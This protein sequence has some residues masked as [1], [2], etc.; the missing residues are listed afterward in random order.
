MKKLTKTIAAI[1]ASAVTAFA[2]VQ[3]PPGL[4][5]IS[6]SDTCAPDDY[7]SCCV[8]TIEYGCDTVDNCSW[9]FDTGAL[10]PY[11]SSEKTCA[12]TY[13]SFFACYSW[14]GENECGQ[15]TTD[16]APVNCPQGGGS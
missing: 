9:I 7:L 15:V 16:C 13:L 5:C 2:C 3:A 4:W 1:V 12:S 11:G 10:Y 6:P 8:G 14:G